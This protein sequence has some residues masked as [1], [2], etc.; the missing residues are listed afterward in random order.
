MLLFVRLEYR[1]RVPPYLTKI[2]IRDYL[3]KIYQLDVKKVNTVNYEGKKRR[4]NGYEFQR[5]AYKMA[6]VTLFTPSGSTVLPNLNIDL[7][8][9]AEEPNISSD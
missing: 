5:P 8:T 4:Y 9:K 7:P 2:E 3:E 1:F 6:I